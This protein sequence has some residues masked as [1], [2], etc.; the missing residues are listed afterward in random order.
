[1]HKNLHSDSEKQS[2]KPLTNAQIFLVWTI[3]AILWFLSVSFLIPSFSI[4]E[5]IAFSFLVGGFV[6]TLLL[7]KDS[8]SSFGYFPSIAFA[9]LIIIGAWVVM[10]SSKSA[11]I[12]VAAILIVLLGIVWELRR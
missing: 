6:T 1:M 10:P 12:G 3:S 5:V 9:V 11:L 2:N 4:I 7:A 8:K